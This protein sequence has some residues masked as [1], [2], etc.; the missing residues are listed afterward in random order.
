MPVRSYRPGQFHVLASDQEVH[1]LRPWQLKLN[2]IIFGAESPAGKAFDVL[3]IVAIIL[4]VL[5]VILESVA[6]VHDRFGQPLYYLEWGFTLAFTVEYIL[7][8]SCVRHPLRYMFSFYGIVDLLSV[9][10]TYLSLIIPG[11]NTL[12]VIRILRILRVFRI[13]KLFHYVQEAEHLAWAMRASSR[14]ILVFLYVVCTVVVVFG[15]IMYLVEGP[16]NGFDSILTSIYWAIVTLTTVGYGDITPTTAFG[17][18]IASATMIT[19]YAIIAV[20]TGIYTA[21]LAQVMRTQ[22]DSRGCLGCGKT[23]HEL[24]ADFCRYCG[25]KLPEIRSK[26]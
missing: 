19:G 8:L 17:Q 18:M 26:D 10:P 22:R 9:I 4:S 24:D 13:L 14:K 1:G 7:R 6:P 16:E 3:L 21:E 11:A 12:L 25:E 23:G 5:A 2:D 15:A 20:P